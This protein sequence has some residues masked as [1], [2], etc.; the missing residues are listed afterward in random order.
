[1]GL[2]LVDEY[3]DD[4]DDDEASGPHSGECEKGCLLG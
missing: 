3:D 4:D 2:V 1:M